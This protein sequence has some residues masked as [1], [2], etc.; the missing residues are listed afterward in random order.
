MDLFPPFLFYILDFIVDCSYICKMSKK[1]ELTKEE[2][3]ELL[4]NSKLRY[5]NFIPTY[6][7][8]LNEYFDELL[9]YIICS[10]IFVKRGDGD[11]KNIWDII[12]TTTSPLLTYKCNLQNKVKS[13]EKI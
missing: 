1:I 12:I 11:Y 7:E 9:N 6:T 10:C 8:L 2:I 13:L 3:S 5:S 4:L